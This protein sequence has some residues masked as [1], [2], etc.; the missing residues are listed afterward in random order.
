MGFVMWLRIG[1]FMVILIGLLM[2]IGYFFGGL[3]V[4]F[5]MF[6]F[7][8]FFN[9]IIYWYSDRIVLSWYNVRIVDEYEVLELYVIVRDFV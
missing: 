2:G 3:N 1:V 4:V 9:F 8:M 6:L 5:I 7:L